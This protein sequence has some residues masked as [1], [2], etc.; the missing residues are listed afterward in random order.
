MPDRTHPHDEIFVLRLMGKAPMIAL[1]TQD[2]QKRMRF[3][4]VM[5]VVG[6]GYDAFFQIGSHE[7]KGLAAF[8]LWAVR[9]AILGEDNEGMVAE[10]LARVQ[11][12]M[13]P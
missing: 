4:H 7:E 6:R 8:E 3:I 9:D 2:V 10:C 5:K 13:K 12:L 11:E 1:D